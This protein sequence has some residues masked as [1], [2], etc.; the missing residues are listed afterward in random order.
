[1][2]KFKTNSDKEKLEPTPEQIACQKDFSRLHHEYETLTKR[3]KHP[4]YRDRK[5]WIL[6]LIIGILLMIV[7]WDEIWG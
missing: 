2:R 4:L 3:G 6:F 5:K 7:F 1:M